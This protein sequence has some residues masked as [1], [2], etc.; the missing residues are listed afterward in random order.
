MDTI[1]HGQ[2]VAEL[3][4]HSNAIYERFRLRVQDFFPGIGPNRDAAVRASKYGTED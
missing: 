1:G 4:G 2:F 3:H